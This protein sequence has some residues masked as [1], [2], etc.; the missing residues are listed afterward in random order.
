M[1]EDLKRVGILEPKTEKPDNTYFIGH[2]GRY[3]KDHQVLQEAN[4]EWLKENNRYISF[5]TGKEYTE[6][7]ALRAD[8]EAYWRSQ[9]IGPKK[10]GGE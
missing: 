10:I 5:W 1:T 3:Y 7:K 4:K 2:D 8:E 6:Y 9:I